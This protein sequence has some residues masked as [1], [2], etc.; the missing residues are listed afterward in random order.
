MEQHLKL[1][2]KRKKEKKKTEFK[3]TTSFHVLKNI[4]NLIDLFIDF[5]NISHYA[6]IKDSISMIEINPS[7]SF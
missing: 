1:K 5:I 2:R 4:L 7:R 6:K 3:G